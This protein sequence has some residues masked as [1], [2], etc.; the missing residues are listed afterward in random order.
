MNDKEKQDRNN[1]VNKMFPIRVILIKCPKCKKMR[2]D[3]VDRF[4]YDSDCGYHEN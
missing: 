4:C 1:K 3:P 2:L